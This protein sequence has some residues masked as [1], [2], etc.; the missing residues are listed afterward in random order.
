MVDIEYK[1]RDDPATFDDLRKIFSVKHVLLLSP[2]TSELSEILEQDRDRV[3]LSVVGTPSEVKVAGQ[4]LPSA[5]RNEIYYDFRIQSSGY[6][7]D[8][9]VA[10]GL[11]KISTLS[12][13]RYNVSMAPEHPLALFFHEFDLY[14]PK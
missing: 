9:P 7:N 1:E 3:L 14:V 11:A 12:F 13:N 5:L 4:R 2:D 10:L 8:M 6:A